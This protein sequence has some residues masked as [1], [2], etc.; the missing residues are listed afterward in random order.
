MRRLSGRGQ[1]WCSTARSSP[2]STGIRTRLPAPGYDGSPE[3]MEAHLQ[4]CR[5]T[6]ATAWTLVGDTLEEA[7]QALE[8][9][10]FRGVA[11]HLNDCELLDDRPA[12]GRALVQRS[13]IDLCRA[14]RGGQAPSRI[15]RNTHVK[16]DN[17]CSRLTPSTPKDPASSA[18]QALYTISAGGFSAT[19]DAFAP[20]R[21]DRRASGSSR[22]SARRPRSRRSGLRC[23]SSHPTPPTSS[24]ARTECR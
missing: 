10:L 6:W 12:E 1:G 5:E 13:C 2:W 16:G 3:G 24:G 15:D 23:S 8:E 7:G 18:G 20:R 22:W 17:P 21:E 19:V 11:Y 14:S 4:T 9:S